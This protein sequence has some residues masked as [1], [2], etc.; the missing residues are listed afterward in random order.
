VIFSPRY[1]VFEAH[2]Q[3]PS[4]VW[5]VKIAMGSLAQNLE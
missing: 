2:F 3:E 5:I 4:T 1:S